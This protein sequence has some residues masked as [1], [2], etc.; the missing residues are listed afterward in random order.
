MTK[1]QKRSTNPPSSAIVY[2]GPIIKKSDR[3]QNDVEDVL[4]KF[5]GVVTSTAGGVIDTNYGNDPASYSISD[6]TNLAALFDEYRVLG[7]QVEFY[8][9][10]RYSKTTVNCTPAIVLIDRISSAT[11]GS[12]QAAIDH[13]SAKKVSWEDPWV[14]VAKMTSIDE[15]AFISTASTSPNTWI[16]FYSSGLSVSTEYGR[17]FVYLRIQM[18]GR[19]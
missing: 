14:E 1:K 18:R 8:P 9:N 4:L 12:Y 17:M 13:E 19:K 10:N 15:A 7:F 2:N 11:L 5:T 3:Q 16:K 6:W